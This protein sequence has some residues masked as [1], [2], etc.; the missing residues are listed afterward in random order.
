MADEKA[1]LSNVERR[2]YEF[3]KKSKIEK[4]EDEM[5]SKL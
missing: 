2:K 1:L 4:K 5:F 3:L